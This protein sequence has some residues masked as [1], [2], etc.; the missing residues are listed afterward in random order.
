LGGAAG[1]SR[2]GG[3][4]GGNEV[5]GV[6]AIAGRSVAGI[7]HRAAPTVGIMTIGGK[8]DLGRGGV[9]TCGRGEPAAGIDFD[10][11]GIIGRGPGDGT[12]GPVGGLAVGGDSGA[13]VGVGGLPAL[14]AVNGSV[15]ARDEGAG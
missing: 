2:V 3:G 6:I 9:I 4:E 10:T 8:P 14:Q 11:V 13:R 1:R 15:R 12:V 5:G 7:G